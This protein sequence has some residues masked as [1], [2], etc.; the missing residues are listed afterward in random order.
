M[1][2]A[3]VENGIVTNI[4]VLYPNNA[5]DFSSAVRCG[6]I[7]VALGDAYN[8]THFYRNGEKVL[9]VAEQARQEV[10]DMQAALTE[11]GVTIDG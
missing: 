2:Y 5:K 7:P 10:K 8:G 9:S 6:D 11:L 1:N 4:I 3:I